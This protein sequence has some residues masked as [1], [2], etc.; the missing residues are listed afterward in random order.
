MVVD[1]HEDASPYC[2]IVAVAMARKYSL[3][4]WSREVVDY[5]L[6]CGRELYLT[7]KVDF[8]A[9]YVIEIPVLKVGKNNFK[10]LAEHLFDSLLEPSILEA[11]L[12][13]ILLNKYGQGIVATKIYSCAVF[14]KNSTYYMFDGYGNS[15]VGLGV[16]PENTGVA[17]LFRFKTLKELVER[18]IY[19]K[20][21]RENV[22]PTEATRFIISTVKVTTVFDPVE[23]I[24]RTRER[25]LEDDGI[26]Y[27]EDAEDKPEKEKPKPKN[28]LGYTK[29]G[30]YLTIQGTFGLGNRFGITG[31]VKKCHFISICA[32]LGLLCKPIKE[33]STKRVDYVFE[34]GTNL[35]PFIDNVNFADKRS[36]RNLLID[37]YFFDIVVKRIHIQTP[38]YMRSF[39]TALDHV[40]KSKHKYLLVQFPNCCFVFYKSKKFFHLFDPYG[41]CT[42]KASRKEDE[43]EDKEQEEFEKEH[44]GKACWLRFETLQQVRNYIHDNTHNSDDSFFFFTVNVANFKKASKWRRLEYKLRADKKKKK[45]KIKPL[46]ILNESEDWLEVYPIP[47]SRMVKHLA[48]GVIRDSPSHKWHFWD[49]EYPND[50]YSLVG[51]LHQ[52]SRGFSRSSR[53]KQTIA[54]CIVAIVMT[55]MYPFINWNT[56]VLNCII[57]NGNAYFTAS[58]GE[59]KDENYELR[60]EDF[61]KSLDVPPYNVRIDYKPL[62]EGTFYVITPTQY[63]LSKALRCFFEIYENRHGIIAC[64]R[65]GSKTKFLAF[66]R[67]MLGEYYMFDCQ[68]IGPPMFLDKF[69]SASYILRCL[70]LNRLL[71]VMTM[72]L[73]GG[74]F[75]IYQIEIIPPGE[76]RPEEEVEQKVTEYDKGEEEEEEEVEDEDGG[77]GEN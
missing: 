1:L 41:L 49:V 35:F 62:I 4:T 73:R 52:T 54:N 75:F 9:F 32:L 33:W 57:R 67:L 60:I 27:G 26:E 55:E 18:F 36:I 3:R 70:S 30:K 59:I 20:K 34:A 37:K 23:M 46:K 38:E 58:V 22:E 21:Q 69:R 5:V 2:S 77:A 45:T 6:E 42:G 16:G 31:T 7:I 71:H 14:L 76:E 19:N 17:C 48:C 25:I 12:S 64:K 40:I 51:T 50:L 44:R 15:L 24:P 74:D 56:S 63:N 13:K 65:E 29:K 61:K 28:V 53:G 72:T 8:A 66:G 47:W 10:V 39:L 68:S 11:A 43:S